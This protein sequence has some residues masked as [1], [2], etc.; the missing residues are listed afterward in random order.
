MSD[1][2]DR[3]AA[4]PD[5]TD[6]ELRRLA[7]FGDERAVAA[8]DV[9]FR[10]GDPSYDFFVVLAGR[11]EIRVGRDGDERVL[12][13][14]GARRF[15]GELSMLN[16]QRVYLTG[17]VVEPGRVLQIPRAQLRTLFGAEP[18]LSDLIL[19]AF[20]ERRRI[21]QGGDGARSIQLLGSRFSPRTVALRGFLVRAGLPHHWLDVE[22]VEDA[23]VLLAGFGVR[24]ADT[25]VVIT[26]TALLRNPSPAELSEHLGLTFSATPGHTFDLVVVGAGPAGLAAAVYGASEGLDTVVLEAGDVGGQAGTSSRIE[27]YLGFPSGL[28]GLELAQRATV[29][30]QKFGASITH[31]CRVAGFRPESGWHVVVLADGSEIPARSV[32]VATGAEYRR[33]DVDGWA[34]LEGA[35]VYYA[36]TETE[37]RLCAGE[38]VVVLGGGNSAGQAAVFLASKGCEVHVVIHGDDL[39]KSMSRYLV[40]RIEA[41]E[42]ITV[43]ERTEVRALLGDDRLTGL[44]WERTAIGTTEDLDVA[45]LLCFIGAIPATGWL[46]RCVATDEHG[47]VL[48]DRD[49]DPSRLP[50][51]WA[52]LDR[53]PL[54]LETSAPGVFAVGDVRGGSVKRVAAAVGEGS[55]AVRSVHAHLAALT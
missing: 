36:A 32:V 41:D 48:T 21:L 14:H 9:L 49:L 3:H 50:P 52:A 30:A 40:D 46:D 39:H 26:S 11:V 12:A 53:Q 1:A 7:R 5:L 37:G 24:P 10:P 16:D 29:Q 44:R 2:T 22:E 34:R 25:P 23:A 47:F 33:P 31:P 35:G 13:D 51:I 8:G 18:D 6:D 20:V 19:R 27:N 42:R 45:A 43:E 28:S 54:P 15:L 38:R 17:V 55:T 4:F